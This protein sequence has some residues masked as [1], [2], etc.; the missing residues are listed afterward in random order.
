MTTT[1]AG[2]T[3]WEIRTAESDLAELRERAATATRYLAA[4]RARLVRDMANCG[5]DPVTV[6]GYVFE[7]RRVDRDIKAHADELARHEANLTATIT[8]LRATA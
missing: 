3:D 4:D 1:T 2:Q 6:D 8:R 7:I 5:G